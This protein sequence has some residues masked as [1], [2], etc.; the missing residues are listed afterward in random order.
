M[1]LFF[2]SIV[3]SFPFHQIYFQFGSSTYFWGNS[4]SF[5]FFVLFLICHNSGRKKE[6]ERERDGSFFFL[7]QQRDGKWLPPTTFHNITVLKVRTKGS[8]DKPPPQSPATSAVSSNTS[9]ALPQ[10]H[11]TVTSQDA[12][13]SASSQNLSGL[14]IPICC[15]CSFP[16]S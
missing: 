13:L 11:Q 10:Q 2:T 6:R 9:P 8:K 12:P 1:T 14:L 5:S 16:D 3:S 15:V 7:F 4:W